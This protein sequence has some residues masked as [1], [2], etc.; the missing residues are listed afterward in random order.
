MNFSVALIAKNEAKTLPRLLGSLKEFH[1]RGGKTVLLDT[2]STDDTIVTARELGCDV[3]PVG[4][5]FI[6]RI[7]G[8]LARELNERFVEGDEGPIVEPGEKLFDFGA[9]RN[10][11]T[12][13]SPTDMIAM[14]DCDEVYTQLNLNE[15]T[16]HIDEG[17]DQFH[18]PFVFA[19]DAA[20]RPLVQYTHSKFYN[21]TKF[22]WV[23]IIHETLQGDGKG[24]SL[25]ES[26][27][28]L[29]HFQ[30][31]ESDRSGYLKALAVDCYMN[32]END[33]N[34]HY[35]GRELYYRGKWRSAI[36]EFQR[37]IAMNKWAAERAQSMNYIG[38]CLIRLGRDEEGLGWYFKSLLTEP[39]RRE[40]L[41]RLA[42]YYY[43]RKHP[44]LTN[45]F[46]TAALEIGRS[47][48][49]AERA[50]HHG[51]YPHELLY[52]AKWH[53]GDREGSR[54]HFFKALELDPSNPRFQ[55]DKQF[56]EPKTP[57]SR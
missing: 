47:S 51:A 13:H 52:W 32:P 8:D 23:G 28:K 20:G 11:I 9:A 31:V 35:L 38:E 33:R 57:E 17:T 42:D 43:R 12:E 5:K 1:A 6:R 45:V 55:A 24:T 49:Y 25:T 56:Y 46:A 48:F 53:M 41:M 26:T 50:Q 27:I 4:E 22:K 14:P 10:H 7:E 21:R 19:H 44:V 29:E 40:A 16:R 18:Y 36:K 54:Q 37:H 39:A 30:N 3:V 2:G 34:S 15:V